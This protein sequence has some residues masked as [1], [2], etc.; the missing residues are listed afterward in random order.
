[1][2]SK[3]IYLSLSSLSLSLM[4]KGWRGWE[5]NLAMAPA[6]H[7]TKSSRSQF[8]KIHQIHL[9]SMLLIKL[10]YESS[11]SAPLLVLVSQT[12][13]WNKNYSKN[14]IILCTAFPFQRPTNKGFQFWRA[15]NHLFLLLLLLKKSSWWWNNW[16]QQMDRS[17]DCR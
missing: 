16:S 6:E 14:F 12:N 1:M 11:P 10:H 13:I 15:F 2:I 5:K 9:H 4:G 8:I 17:I 7:A 3:W